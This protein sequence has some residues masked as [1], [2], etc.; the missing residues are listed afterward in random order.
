MTTYTLSLARVVRC[1][2]ADASSSNSIA[3]VRNESLAGLCEHGRQE[4]RI[5]ADIHCGH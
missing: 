4:R 3:T 5:L 2:P 1:V